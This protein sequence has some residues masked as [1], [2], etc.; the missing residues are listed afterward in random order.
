MKV[1][2]FIQT[3]SIAEVYSVNWSVNQIRTHNRSIKQ[4]VIYNRSINQIKIYDRSIKIN[5]NNSKRKITSTICI[6]ALYGF[7]ESF[8]TMYFTIVRS[9]NEIGVAKVMR[10]SCKHAERA[11]N[12]PLV[13]KTT[14]TERLREASTTSRTFFYFCVSLYRSPF[15]STLLRLTPFEALGCKSCLERMSFQKFYTY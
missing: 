14:Y 7:A 6:V 13:L 12:I 9:L 10:S 15:H 4:I 1:L 5:H 8:W 11:I 3:D 2:F